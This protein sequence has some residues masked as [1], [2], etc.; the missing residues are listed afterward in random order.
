MP[1]NNLYFGRLTPG[2][3]ANI[4]VELLGR[5]QYQRFVDPCPMSFVSDGT[6]SYPYHF[7]LAQYV[8]EITSQYGV[9]FR[10]TPW[11]KNL[12]HLKSLVEKSLPQRIWLAT[13]NNDIFDTVINSLNCVSI[14]INYPE[15]DYDFMRQKWAR[16]M[17]GVIMT[18]VRY[19][20]L[21]KQFVSA[22]EV[23]QWLLDHGSAKFGYNLPRSL[24]TQADVE[25]NLRDL[26]EKSSMQKILNRLDCNIS[27]NDWYFY[28]KYLEC[29]G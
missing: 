11:H 13:Y 19:I 9:G 23:E 16:W 8:A 10:S 15:Q 17:T 18:D 1:E 26:F 14:S 29:S 5:D 22:V 2:G 27:K 24:Y 28:E 25:I 7:M 12:D 4:L 20:D 21:R 6:L 3:T